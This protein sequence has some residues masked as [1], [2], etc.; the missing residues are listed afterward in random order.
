MRATVITASLLL[1]SFASAPGIAIGAPP[2]PTEQFARCARPTAERFTGTPPGHTLLDLASAH[3]FS[4]GAGVKVAVIDT[5]VTPHPRLPGLTGGG[6][7]VSS[8]D[9][10]DD[11]DLHGTLVAGIIAARPSPAD[12]YIGVAPEATIISIRQ[13]SGAYRAKSSDRDAAAVGAGYGP[14]ETLAAAI[15]RAVDLG[16]D[17]VNISETA[18]VPAAQAAGDGAVRD[19]LRDAVVRDVVVVAAAGNLSDG[20]QCREQNPDV[21]GL[22]V[23]TVATPARLSPLVLTVGATQASDGRAAPFTLRGPWVSVAA[24]GADVVGLA[25]TGPITALAGPTGESGLA[26]TSYAAPYVSGTAALIRSRFPDLTAAEVIHRIVATAHGGGADTAVGRGVIDPVA[27]LTAQ[28]P[29]ARPSST[30]RRIAAPAPV[31]D[32]DSGLRRVALTAG[33]AAA[34]VALSVMLRPARRH[35]RTPSRDR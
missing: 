12:D 5:G 2:S 11:C 21:V 1:I 34:T 33:L 9:G 24:P 32:G 4:R 16:A 17:V 30:S 29:P 15:R 8:G 6:D 3:R 25:P 22:P 13:S 26:G 31:E 18:C 19:A 28:S 35:A 27:A 10:L 20:T 14:L 7:Y 23:V